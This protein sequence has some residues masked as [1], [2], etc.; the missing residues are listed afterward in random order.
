MTVSEDPAADA[1]QNVWLRNEIDADRADEL[2]RIV[3]QAPDIR[4]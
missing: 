2:L 4:F 3:L 1:K